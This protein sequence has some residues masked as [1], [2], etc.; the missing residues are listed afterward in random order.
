MNNR[1]H[2]DEALMLN[3]QQGDV[4]SFEV[5][6]ERHK[7]RIYNY[8]YRFLGDG[9]LAEDIMQDVFMSVFKGAGGYQKKAKFTT[10]IYTIARNKCIDVKR[11]ARYRHTLSMDSPT[12]G[13]DSDSP[14]LGSRISNGKRSVEDRVANGEMREI[15]KKAVSQLPEEQREVFIMRQYSGVQFKEIAEITGCT[16]STVKSRMRYAMNN[17]R[18]ILE[19]A[20]I[21]R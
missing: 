14:T 17:L 13:A 19:N 1:A 10:W 20:G 16:E 15:L 18:Q 7:A 2:T 12:K 9:N 4:A 11:K 5:L 3:Y 21:V 8:I 6:F